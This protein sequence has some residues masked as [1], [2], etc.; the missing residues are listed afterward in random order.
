[1]KTTKF[2]NY[3]LRGIEVLVTIARILITPIFLLIRIYYWIWDFDY[4]ERFKR[5]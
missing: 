1:M 3:I 2:K 5:F 4:Y